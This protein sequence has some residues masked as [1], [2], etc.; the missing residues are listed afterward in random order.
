M[1]YNRFVK[2]AHSLRLPDLP[3]WL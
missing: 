1:W 2:S 3:W